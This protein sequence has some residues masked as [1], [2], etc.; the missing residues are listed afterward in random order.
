MPTEDMANHC[1]NISY[2]SGVLHF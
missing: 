1:L 2:I